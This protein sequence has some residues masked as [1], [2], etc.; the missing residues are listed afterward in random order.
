MMTD[1]LFQGPLFLKAGARWDPFHNFRSSTN[2]VKC[3]SIQDWY[4]ICNICRLNTGTYT[5]E[6]PIGSTT[7]AI[8]SKYRFEIMQP[9]GS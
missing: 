8:T 1:I 7:G 3:M 2:Y 6:P 9:F 5:L 4:Q